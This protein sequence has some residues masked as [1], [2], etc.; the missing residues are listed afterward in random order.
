[1]AVKSKLRS[2]TTQLSGHAANLS[3]VI[4]AWALQH[5]MPKCQTQVKYDWATGPL[6]C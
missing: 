5:M 6:F 2:H 1:M 4:Y 3:A